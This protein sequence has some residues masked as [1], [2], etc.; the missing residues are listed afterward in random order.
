MSRRLTSWSAMGLGDQA[1]AVWAVQIRTAPESIPD[2][3]LKCPKREQRRRNL[4]YNRID[5]GEQ[6]YTPP[7][8]LDSVKIQIKK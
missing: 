4:K 8:V 7:Q 2:N 5:Q 1:I 3:G 6:Q